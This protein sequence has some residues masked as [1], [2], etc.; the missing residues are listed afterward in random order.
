MATFPGDWCLCGGWAV[1][2]WLGALSRDHLD[3]DVVVFQ[4]DLPALLR[5]FQGWKLHAHDESDPD[6]ETQW[7]GRSLV[8]PAHVHVRD[9]EVNLDVRVSRRDGDSIVI[10]PGVDMDL[11]QAITTGAWGIPVLAPQVVLY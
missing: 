1:D 7:Q 3:I 10:A 2:A 11:E 8:L 4:D 5:H 6:S 9:D